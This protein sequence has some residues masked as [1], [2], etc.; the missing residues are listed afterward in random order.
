MKPQLQ[1]LIRERDLSPFLGG[2]KRT[3]IK[4][5]M[6]TDPTFP[7]PVYPSPRRASFVE[8]ELIQWQQ[9]KI[10]ARDAA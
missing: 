2:L 1:K 3:A 5:L 4:E 7:K 8:S 10:A 6:R 9:N